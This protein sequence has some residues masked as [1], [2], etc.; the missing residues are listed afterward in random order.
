M[1]WRR[2][3][4]TSAPVALPALLLCALAVPVKLAGTSLLQHSMVEMLVMLVVAIGIYVFVGNSGILSF[5]HVSFMAIGAYATAWL[6]L[7]LP[8]KKLN[9][10]G[11]PSFL[12]SLSIPVTASAIISGLLAALAGVVIG[13]PLLRLSGIAASIATLAFLVIVYIG[14]SSWDSVTLGTSSIVGLP[15]YTN[16]WAALGWAVAM[17]FLA[18]AYQISRHGLLLRAAR[19]DEAAAK[20]IG[21]KVFRERLI[22]WTLSAF[23]VGVG[24]VLYAHFL[25]AISTEAFYLNMT[26]ISLA[27][28]VVGGTGSLA[29]AVLGVVTIS[30]LIEGLRRIEKGINIGDV[31]F[32][33]PPGAQ[34]I[35]IA[36]TM[37]VILLLRPKGLSGNREMRLPSGWFRTPSR[38]LA[39]AQSNI[40]GEKT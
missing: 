4:D 28:L 17:I 5:G 12:H 33:L 8:L 19:D 15:P 30:L 34:E 2:I 1:S 25:G 18:Y 14:Y 3:A 24:G 21:I 6:T 36:V 37:L 7:P 29:G 39:M 23:I 26:F 13:V 16:L 40:K 22:A 31:A 32:S 10:P 27:M 35:G 9:M 11:L 38:S 20:A